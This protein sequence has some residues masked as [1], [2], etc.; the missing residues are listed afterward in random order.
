MEKKKFHIQP[1]SKKDRSLPFTYEAWVDIFEGAGI[2]PV[3]DH[4][5]SDTICGLIECLAEK[6]IAPD[7]VQLY[8]LYRGEHARLDQAV[9]TDEEGVWLS[10]PALCRA[11]EKYFEHSQEEC[12]RGHVADGHCAFEDRDRESAGPAW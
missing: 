10:R 4:Y 12:Y 1:R 7:H 9:C 3:F 11:L 8:G 5:F 2:E 6:G